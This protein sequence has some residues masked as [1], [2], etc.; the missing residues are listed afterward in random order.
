[1]AFSRAGDL[2][3]SFGVPRS[4]DLP[5]LPWEHLAGRLERVTVAIRHRQFNL[6][7]TGS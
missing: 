7:V 5:E 6:E 1:M 4:Y 3:E 2:D